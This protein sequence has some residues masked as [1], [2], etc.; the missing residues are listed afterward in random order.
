MSIND[1]LSDYNFVEDIIISGGGHTNDV[2]TNSY[3]IL[4]TKFYNKYR[5]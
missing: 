2:I 3:I 5:N 4:L 1:F